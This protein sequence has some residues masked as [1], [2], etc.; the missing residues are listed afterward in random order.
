MNVRR[1][2]IMLALLD[3]VA[4]E[5]PEGATDENIVEIHQE[6]LRRG[7]ERGLLERGADGSISVRRR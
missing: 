5:H 7:I 2:K 3:E 6:A 1:G 4:A